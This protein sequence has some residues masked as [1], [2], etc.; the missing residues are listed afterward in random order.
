MRA[1]IPKAPFPIGNPFSLTRVWSRMSISTPVLRRSNLP[2]PLAPMI[3]R[4]REHDDVIQLLR[5]PTVRLI[6]LTGPGG[7]GKTRLAVEVGRAVAADPSTSSGQAFADGVVYVALDPIRDVALVLPTIAQTIGLA[8]TGRDTIVAEL[9][10]F[11]GERHVLLLLDNFEQVEDAAAQIA[12]LLVACPNLKVLAT[13]RTPLEVYGER[14]Y[15]IPPLALPSDDDT[16]ATET[17]AA[18]R[19][20]AERAVEVKPAFALTSDNTTTVVEICRRLDGL[21]LAIELAAARIKFLSPDALLDRLSSRLEVLTSGPRDLPRRQ[22]T[23][24]DAIAWSHDLLT[25]D[26]RALFRRLAAF[27]GSFTL[28]TAEAVVDGQTDRRTD[29]QTDREDSSCS[30]PSVRLSVSD[31]DLLAALVDESLVRQSDE[32]SGET[33]FSMFQTIHEFAAEQLAASGEEA[34]VRRAHAEFFAALAER[35]APELIGAEQFAWLDRLDAEHDNLR[36]ALN[37]TIDQADASLAQRIAGSL[38]RFWWVR[39]H[40]AEGKRWYDR[41]LSLGDETPTPERVRS[42]FGAGAMAEHL[43]DYDSAPILYR[44][45]LDAARAIGDRF[46][47]AQSTEALGLVAQDQGRYDEAVDL[48]KQ[49]REIFAE[50][51]F[52][53]GLAST[54]HNLGS[55]SYYRG[56]I[57]DAEARYNET[58]ELVRE[59]GDQ[60]AASVILGNLGVIAAARGDFARAKQLQEETL[61]LTRAAKD[62]AATAT[63]LLNLGDSERQLGDL[64]RAASLI[65]E[66]LKIFEDQ[67]AMRH[68]AIAL[69]SLGQI[70]HDRGDTT[71]AVEHLGRGLALSRSCHDAMRTAAFLEALGVEAAGLGDARLGARLLGAAD[72]LL[73]QIGAE[74]SPSE[75]KEHAGNL[76]AVRTAAGQATFDTAWAEGA[77][78]SLDAIVAEAAAVSALA[79]APSPDSPADVEAARQIGLTR[80]ELD[81]LRLFVAGRSNAEIAESLA[82]SLPTATAQIGNLYTKLGVDSRAGVT[83]TAFKHGLV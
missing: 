68:A 81:V 70:D 58:L 75:L 80:R 79:A 50:I 10:A 42:L 53:R 18:I 45:A 76:A 22:Q 16:A 20:F 19:L 56:D 72:A 24:R 7:I 67:G 69:V 25:A 1:G 63:A 54:I 48:H 9:T 52:R 64:D 57:E 61:V 14:E 34:V 49:A 73:T 13:S 35:A 59:L 82:I 12:E 39:G 26:E 31:L 37:W 17:F 8:A 5:T 6:T 11:L 55:I 74:R 66:A 62:D 44:A 28:E 41:V 40:V 65:G 36:A 32:A 60:R 47:I 77:A 30:C 15:P 51:G 71:L 46:M 33:R 29:G 3:D 78:A 21:P 27:A 4:E 23:L 43:G 83:A 2:L 38:W